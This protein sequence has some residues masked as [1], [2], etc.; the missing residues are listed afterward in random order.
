[1]V[2]EKTREIDLRESAEEQQLVIFDLGDESFG[3]DVSAVRE[4]IRMQAVTRV[5]GTP[6]FVEG[7][8]NLRG[9][10]IPMV[11]LRK[12]FQFDTVDA[13]KDSRIVVIESRG[14]EVGVIVDAV[15]EVMRVPADSIEP[16]S[17][18]MEHESTEYL[19]GIAK[20]G[21]KL[22][23]FHFQAAFF[24]FFLC[25]SVGSQ[26]LAF[27]KVHFDQHNCRIENYPYQE[28]RRQ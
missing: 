18:T 16:V 28:S 13:T 11:D 4:I 6:H 27:G 8:I 21:E 20:V 2:S 19:L 1:M 25:N 24:S 3:V 9:K 14:Q 22:I 12:S 15:T 10:I 23:I 17:K 26:F 7:I 5:P